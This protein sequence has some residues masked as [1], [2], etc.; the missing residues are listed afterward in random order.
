MKM[1]LKA[2][3][4]ELA[5]HK[6]EVRPWRS[7]KRFANAKYLVRLQTGSP[8]TMGDGTQ[9]DGWEHVGHFDTLE[10]AAAAA[11]ETAQDRS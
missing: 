10:N 11:R 8:Q 6:M 2:L 3:N 9:W 7:T 5:E 1:T 4:A